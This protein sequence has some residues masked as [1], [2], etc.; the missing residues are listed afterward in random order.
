L[1]GKAAEPEVISGQAARLPTLIE[2]AQANGADCIILD[3]APNATTPCER[4][5][6][7]TSC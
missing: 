5:A 1:P 6:S 4:Q 3:T 2:A 7:P